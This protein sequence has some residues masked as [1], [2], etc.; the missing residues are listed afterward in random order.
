MFGEWRAL[1]GKCMHPFSVTVCR[2]LIAVFSFANFFV[3]VVVHQNIAFFPF[4]LIVFLVFCFL[5]FRL[6]HLLTDTR[7][8]LS[9]FVVH[10]GRTIPT[11]A[12]M[13]EPLPAARS[14]Q[15]KERTS[16]DSKNDDRG[17][18]FSNKTKRIFCFCFCCFSCLFVRLIRVFLLNLPLNA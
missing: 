9:G 5:L 2:Y 17:K 10:R 14:R 6:I 8:T 7:T 15:S 11:L 1:N 18:Y 12:S 4:Y 13:Q 3:V 16:V